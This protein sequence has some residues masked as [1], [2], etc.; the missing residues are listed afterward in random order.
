MERELN[1]RVCVVTGASSGIGEATARAFAT[2][3]AKVAL[4][5]RRAERVQALAGELGESALPLE[6]DVRNLDA[7]RAAAEQIGDRFG[8]VD[9]LVNNAG[10]MLNSPFRAGLVEEWRTMVETNVLGVLY[11]THVFVDDLCAGGG[12][13]VNLS[14]VA[15]RTARPDANVYNATKHA[16]TGW[17]DALRQELLEYDVRVVAVEP[18]AVSTE[19]PEHISHPET[20]AGAAAFYGGQ[21]EILTAEDI[22]SLIVYAVTAPER[23]SISELLVRPLRQVL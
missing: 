5:A 1:G 22:A 7:L 12:D 20:R 6:A 10:V 9:C 21:I 15:G 4:L 3:G 17:S 11:A 8:R 19:L 13:V 2:A 23:V 18:G 14:S 16:I